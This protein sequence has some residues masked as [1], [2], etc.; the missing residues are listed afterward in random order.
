MKG[1]TRGIAMVKVFFSYSHD[2]ETDRNEL[3]KHL[4]VLKREG[5]IETW[6]DR[7]ILA[8]AA[9]GN[10]IDQNLTESNLVLLL[11]SPDFLESDY[12]YS[13]E[14]QK[15]LE[16]RSQGIAWVIPIIVEHCDW[17]HTPLK[18]LLA[19]PKDGKP[20]SDYPNP[21]KAFNEIANEIRRVIAE[22]SGK[23]TKTN[24]PKSDGSGTSE[25]KSEPIVIDNIRSG[26]L[27]IKKKFTDYEKDTFK[28]DA[29]E[30]IA[31]YFKNSLEELK[32]RN[33]N[34]NCM[35]DKEANKFY[36]TI[37]RSGGEIASCL[38]VNR[39]GNNSWGGIT[40]SYDKNENSINSSLNVEDDGYSLF[41]IPMMSMTGNK[42]KLSQKGAAE[43]Y[44]SMLIDRLQY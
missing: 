30:Y 22:I 25:S 23:Q 6:H 39:V 42:D 34:I 29:F 33:S 24:K 40:Y 1:C 5:L 36:V 44:W 17:K 2:D 4:A 3:E 14:M 18:D 43:F 35:F 19:C 15:A 26:N 37:Y 9:L 11:V 12:C 41:L 10:E 28:K 20:I 31:K 8:G 32:G 13:K 7:R 21:N 38:I 27:R 16:M